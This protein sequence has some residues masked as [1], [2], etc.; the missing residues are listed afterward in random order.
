MKPNPEPIWTAVRALGEAPGRCVL[1]GDSLSGIEGARAAG[2][3]V[4]GYAN[5]AFKAGTFQAAGADVVIDSMG[6]M[7]SALMRVHQTVEGT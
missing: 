6:E 4:V 2:V 5:R 7:A 1:V 3:K